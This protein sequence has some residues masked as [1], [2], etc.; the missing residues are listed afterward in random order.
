M[1][2]AIIL[3]KFARLEVL[4]EMPSSMYSPTTTR[5]LDSSDSTN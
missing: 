3:W 1:A 5:S 4:P 2:S